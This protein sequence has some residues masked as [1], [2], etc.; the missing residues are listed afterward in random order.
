[1]L[2][3]SERDE[4]MGAL[5]IGLHQ[6]TDVTL[7]GA[8]H[9]VTQAYCS[10]LPVAYSTHSSNDWEPFARLVLDASYEAALR[11][12]AYNRVSTVNRTVFVTLL[13]GGAFGNEMSWITD[14]LS[15][16]LAIV[17]D[18]D[19]DVAIVSHGSSS[20]GVASLLR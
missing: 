13:G 16:A 6:N 3:T 20:P 17:A 19:L 1:M 14:A 11:A 18:V 15:R 2:T 4:L 5:R 7:P 9:L 10:A 12:A 8:G